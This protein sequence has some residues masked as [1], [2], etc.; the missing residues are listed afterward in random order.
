M[1]ICFWK[2]VISIKCKWRNKF[3]IHNIN[4][5]GHRKSACC[6]QLLVFLEIWVIAPFCHW[7]TQVFSKSCCHHDLKAFFEI[8]YKS[9]ATFEYYRKYEVK[10]ARI[11]FKFIIYPSCERALKNG[12]VKSK[13]VTKSSFVNM[14]FFT[15]HNFIWLLFICFLHSAKQLGKLLKT[16]YRSAFRRVPSKNVSVPPSST[17]QKTRCSTL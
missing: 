4:L 8:G 3:L 14:I 10:M 5:T 15:S 1:T 2:R 11:L 12:R 9:V 13:I 6:I 17:Y 16:T 7:R